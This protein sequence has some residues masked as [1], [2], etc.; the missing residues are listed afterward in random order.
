[1][2]MA[3][4]RLPLALP[5][6]R[7]PQAMAQVGVVAP[8]GTVGVRPAL[9]SPAGGARLEMV[10]AQVAARLKVLQAGL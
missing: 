7:Q 6:R 8:A 4:G 5:S 3:A 1:M 2:T 9:Q 10:A